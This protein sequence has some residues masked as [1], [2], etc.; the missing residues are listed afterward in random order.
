MPQALRQVLFEEHPEKNCELSLQSAGPLRPHI[1]VQ[2]Q[3]AAGAM[4]LGGTQAPGG[5]YRRTS[6]K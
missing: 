5:T 4:A 6:T 2:V 3:E 1:Q